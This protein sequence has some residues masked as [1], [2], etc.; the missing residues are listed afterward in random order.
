MASIDV[1]AAADV[2]LAWV[3]TTVLDATATDCVV[4]IARVANSFV[5]PPVACTVAVAASVAVVAVR[6]HSQSWVW[7]A[8]VA[9]VVAVVLVVVAAA[10]VVVAVATLMP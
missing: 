6:V 4:A 9:V 2:L 8:I 10:A 5:A 1:A 3:A 7:Q